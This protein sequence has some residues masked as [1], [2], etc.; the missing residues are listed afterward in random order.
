MNSKQVLIITEW[1]HP[2]YRRYE[3]WCDV[4]WENDTHVCF[5]EDGKEET[6]YKHREPKFRIK[7][8]D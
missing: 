5:I 6:L 3:N 8:E 7:P 1:K 2:C 4:V